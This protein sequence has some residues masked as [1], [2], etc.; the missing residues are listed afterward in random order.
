MWTRR[1]SEQRPEQR[2]QAELRYHFEHLVEDLTAQGLDPAEARRRAQLEFGGLPQIAEEC[3]DVRGHWLEDLRKDLRYTAR[4]LRQSP[5]FLTVAVLSLAL[6]IGANTA[7]FTLIDAIM[8]RSLPVPQPERLV[9]VTRLSQDGKPTVVSYPLFE[10]FRDNLKSISGAAV[11]MASGSTI[12]MDGAEEEVSTEL[13]SG[14]YYSLLRLE[15]AAG[16]LL[17][18]EDDTV[19]P[20]QPAAV[21]SYRYWDRRFGR[22]PAALGKTFAFLDHVYTIVGVAPER[23]HGTTAGRDPDFTMPVS[24]TLSPTQRR[25]DSF[26]LLDL[27]ARLA[28]GVSAREAD[29]EVQVIWPRFR[30]RLASAVPEKSRPAILRQRAGVVPAANGFTGLLEE[31]SQAL[32]VLMGIVGLVLLLACA[33]LS[34]LLLARAASRQREISIRLALG[35][36]GGRLVRQFLAESLVLAALGGCVGLLLAQWFGSVLLALMANGR[37]L[38]LSTPADWRVLAFTL[39]TSLAA[40]VLAG[41]APGLHA[42]RTNLNPGLKSPR[43]DGHQCIGKLL[44]MAQLAISMV[45]LVGAALFVNTLVKLYRVD[46]GVRTDGVAMFHVRFTRYPEAQ[47]L[48]VRAAILQGLRALP[49]VASASAGQLIPAGGGIWT[50]TVQVDGYRFRPDESEEVAFNVVA[51]QYFITLGTPLL[52]GREFGERDT[53]TAPKVA[54][55]NQSFARYFFGNQSPL[56]RRV[57]SLNVTYEIVGVVKDTKYFDL[58]HEAAR[59]L[60]TSWMQRPGDQPSN[61]YYFARLLAG[62]GAGLTPSFDRLVREVDPALRLRREWPATY[63]ATIA[64]E[65][66]TE[67]IMALLGGF[68][69]ALALL[70]ACLGIFGVMA[71]QVSRRVNEIGLRMALGASRSG[72]VSLVMHDVAV[73]LALGSITGAAAARALTGLA[74]S[75]LF[76]V[77]PSDPGVFLLA[78]AVLSVAALAAAWLPARRAS[79]VDPMVALRHE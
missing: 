62:D 33:N 25:E 49:G 31:Y 19:A 35:A 8:L 22:D 3:R 37:T 43:S 30:E 56:G 10:F 41:L 23:F 4:T 16:R 55:V 66:V 40:C 59:T 61:Y 38:L 45:L 32:L 42:L 34:G 29:A 67:R 46:P 44:V 27:I 71:F 13:V 18:P 77:T 69:G 15:P 2:L 7:I 28:P 78:A 64:S 53:S 21:I 20:A 54:I 60:Y 1:Q 39:G 12:V 57:T 11:A 65:L 48:T 58:R 6:G 50:R 76:G 47:S 5:A 74:G 72:I 24:M 51:P 26:N 9:Q 75:M 79:R 73:M 68:F 17:Q 14:G 70:V 63:T 36:S 52:A